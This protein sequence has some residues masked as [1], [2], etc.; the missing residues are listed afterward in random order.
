[1]L[2]YKAMSKFL[3]DGVHAEVLDFP[4]HRQPYRSPLAR[5]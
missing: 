1:M 2:V 4:T 3:G 5:Q